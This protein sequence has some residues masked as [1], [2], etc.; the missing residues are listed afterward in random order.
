MKNKLKDIIIVLEFFALLLVV[1][2]INVFKK[3]DIISIT[4]RRKLAQLPEITSDTVFSGTVSSSFE[5]YTTDQFI[6]RDTLKELKYWFSINVF[7][8]QDDNKLFVKDKSIYK[9]EYPLKE[10]AIESMADKMNNV[11]NKYLQGMNV[12]Y[13]VIPDKC[14]YINDGHLKMNYNRIEEILSDKLSGM[15][16]I[17]IKQD[18][19][20]NSFY[21][22]DLHWR[23][24]QIISTADVISKQMNDKGISSTY[25]EQEAGKFYGVYYGQV[26]NPIDPDIIKYLTNN[27]IDA[28]TTYNYETDKQGKVYDIDKYNNSQDKYDIFVSGPTALITIENPNANCDKELLLF[29]DSFGSS[30]AP[31]LIENYKKIT[32]IDLRYM[33]S[34]LLDQ[35]ID[36]NNQDVLFLYSGMVLN[37]NI[38]K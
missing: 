23:Q 21:K 2:I 8:Q 18:L 3:D 6:A 37:Q 11:Y 27:T 14:Y 17:D 5:K 25:N 33:N 4:E 12:Y 31:L 10:A 16:Y 20:E 32:L 36:F 30:I 26:S 19:N 28:C 29:R 34:S 9:M 7:R 35:Y 38:L 13:S 22:T 1:F 15:Q 24:E